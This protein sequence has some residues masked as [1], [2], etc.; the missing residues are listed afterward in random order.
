MEKIFFSITRWLM[1][2]G[3]TIA[4]TFLIGGGIYAFKLYT[5]SQDTTV[6]EDAY[7][8]KEPE[9]SFDTYKNNYE[10]N[11][12]E[13]EAQRARIEKYILKIISK[14]S[15][16]HGYPMGK[17]PSGLL[18]GKAAE[19]IAF[20]VSTKMKGDKP[21]SFAA[22]A[23]CHGEDGRGMNGQSPS[24]L[25]LPIYNG[26]VSTTNKGVVYAPSGTN[27]NNPQ[28]TDPLKTYSANLAS[29]INKYAIGVG[30]EGT[31]ADGMFSLMQIL[32]KR[33][34]EESFLLLKRQLKHELTSLLNYG[35]KLNKAKKPTDD[36]IVW[37]DFIQWFLEDF[38]MQVQAENQKYQSSLHTL[39][40]KRNSK[41]NKALAA[42]VEL[43]QLL[44]A[45]GAALIVFILLTMIL[46]L[47]KIELNTRIGTKD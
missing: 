10:K 2:I 44:T 37:K 12:K 41:Q 46:V 13:K 25:E 27:N 16:G 11:Q 20:F 30:Q 33:Y 29:I 28:Y 5:V 39:E 42:K 15:K 18:K 35:Q 45:L 34:N 17:M 32:E 36:A 24:L 6:N 9:V 26:H 7:Q 43:L 31:T 23:A 21:I 4:F 40:N 47:F 19:N 3:A 22:C 38:N 8:T 14:G 1:L